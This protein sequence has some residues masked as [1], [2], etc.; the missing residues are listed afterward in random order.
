[1]NTS[2]PTSAR[3]GKPVILAVNKV[4]GLEREDEMLAEFHALGFPM[5]ALSAEHGHNIRALEEELFELLPPE[6][7]EGR[8]ELQNA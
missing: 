5:L 6:D 4:D 7:P 2:R 1:M 3:A 8:A